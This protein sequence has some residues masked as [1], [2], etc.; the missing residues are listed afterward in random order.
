MTTADRLPAALRPL[1]ELTEDAPGLTHG[2][3][4]AV[5]CLVHTAVQVSVCVTSAGDQDS[6]LPL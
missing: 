3:S 2:T 5:L 1:P 4:E 6:K